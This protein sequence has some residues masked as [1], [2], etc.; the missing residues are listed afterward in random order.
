M[1]P[2]TD[3]TD[4]DLLIRIAT[5]VESL[6]HRLFGNGNPGEIDKLR[7]DQKKTQEFDNKLLGGI[8]VLSF[9]LTVFG[10]LLVRHLW[11]VK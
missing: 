4:H 11:M 7:A 9:M 8:L 6:D 3:L 2:H 5:V 1:I 10:S